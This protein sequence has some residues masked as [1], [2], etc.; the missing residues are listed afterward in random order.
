M[1]VACISFNI[2]F[3]V[4]QLYYLFFERMRL[5]KKKFQGAGHND[6]E[7]YSVYLERLR[8]FVMVELDN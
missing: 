1:P 6:V 2:R 5:F 8:Q 3:K 7:L 4:T